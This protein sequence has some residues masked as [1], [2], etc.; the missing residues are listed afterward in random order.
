MTELVGLED[1]R[2]A[3]ELISGVTRVTPVESCRPLTA[4]LGGPVW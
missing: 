1:V 3:R 4:A 2:V